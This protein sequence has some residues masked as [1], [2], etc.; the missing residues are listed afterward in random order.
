MKIHS[1]LFNLRI[2]KDG[3][4]FIVLIEVKKHREAQSFKVYYA[5]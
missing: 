1:N 2:T 4:Q 5:L 3:A